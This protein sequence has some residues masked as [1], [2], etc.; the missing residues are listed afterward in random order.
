MEKKTLR[1]MIDIF[2]R[3]QHGSGKALCGECRELLAYAE[4]R[5]QAC[6]FG[7]K[8]PKCSQCEVHCYKPAMREKIRN[9]MRFA[10]P[11]MI[12]RHPVLALRHIAAGKGRGPRPLSEVQA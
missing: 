4:E 3:G 10:G 11:R 6:R 7:E 5:L 12:A 8:K 1:A 9:V 2:C